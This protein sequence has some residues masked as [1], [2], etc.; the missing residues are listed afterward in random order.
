MRQEATP[1]NKESAANVWTGKERSCHNCS[2][3]ISLKSELLTNHPV[4]EPFC[5]VTEHLCVYYR[6]KAIKKLHKVTIDMTRN[7]DLT[8]PETPK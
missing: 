6:H 3:F 5:F 8:M 4:N 7:I 1:Y 2:C